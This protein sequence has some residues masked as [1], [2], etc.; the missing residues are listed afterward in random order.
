MSE[1][2]QFTAQVASLTQQ[3]QVL[4]QRQ[5]AAEQRAGEAAA[6]AAATAQNGAGEVNAT[7]RAV[8][9]QQSA[10]LV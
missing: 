2:E 3:M 7:V 9:E 1:A 6:A 5:Q 10:M 4:V 8:M